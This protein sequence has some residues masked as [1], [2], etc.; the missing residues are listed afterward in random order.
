MS[1]DFSIIWFRRDLRLYDNLALLE[2]NKHHSI[3][4]IFIFD[5]QLEEYNNIGQPSLWWLEKSLLNLNKSLSN[6]LLIFEGD[7]KETIFKICYKYNIKN[8][9][10][11]RCYEPDRIAADT[12]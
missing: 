7:S 11:N 1:N 12:K 8:V 2:A 10:W 3:L 9:Y 4:P 5:Y 6:S